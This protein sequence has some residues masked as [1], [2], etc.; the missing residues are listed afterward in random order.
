MY[1][2]KK[3]DVN[4]LGECLRR[5]CNTALSVTVRYANVKYVS[6]N[7]SCVRWIKPEYQPPDTLPSR[8]WPLMCDAADEAFRKFFPNKNKSPCTRVYM[9]KSVQGKRF[10]DER[11]NWIKRKFRKMISEREEG[12]PAAPCEEIKKKRH[13]DVNGKIVDVINAVPWT[14]LTKFMLSDEHHAFSR[15]CRAAHDARSKDERVKGLKNAVLCEGIGMYWIARCLNMKEHLRMMVSS[16][17]LR[18]NAGLLKALRDR[19][20]KDASDGCGRSALHRAARNGPT[21]IVKLLLD[22]GAY[23]NKKDDYGRT[24]LYYA[25]EKGHT[26]IVKLLLDA[27]SDKDVKNGYGWTPLH[28]AAR[29]GHTLIVKLLIDA[30][31]NKNDKDEDG[32][33][34]LHFAAQY[35]HTVIVKLLQD[36]GA[37]NEVTNYDGRTP[38]H[39]AVDS[40]HTDIVK[41][42]LRNVSE[43]VFCQVLG[44]AATSDHAGAL[45]TLLTAGASPNETICVSTR[46]VSFHPVKLFSPHTKKQHTSALGHAVVCG[47]IENVRM[48][49][50]A[51]ADPD[52]SILITRE[53]RHNRVL[54]ETCS[55]LEYAAMK[56]H[57]DM[58]KLLLD[59]GV[60]KEVKDGLGRTPLHVAAHAAARNGWFDT[61]KVL[62]DA[63]P[64]DCLPTT[65]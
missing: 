39:E 45:E 9:D 17:R 63:G 60:D 1:T 32:T 40:R 62:R 24:P 20:D 25:A 14:E 33:T 51:S 57:T 58:V 26:C 29:N 2:R 19:E 38:L 47:N 36:A 43:A 12:A 22:S 28:L 41:L 44:A 27:E 42:L 64:D 8:F 10:V 53:F 21:L 23:K 7:I 52:V 56:G 59:A 35:G 34:P 55:A 4:E 46:E 50:D 5:C 16:T 54:T 37:D 11:L 13:K 48:M 6:V 15:T 3:L 65:L 31:A 61:V 30:G 49:L 18:N